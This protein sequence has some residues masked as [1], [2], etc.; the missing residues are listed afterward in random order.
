[1]V[2]RARSRRYANTALTSAS[3]SILPK[4]GIC[5][6]PSRMTVRISA[7]LK[8]S[9]SFA[10][11]RSGGAAWKPSAALRPAGTAW[12]LAQARWNTPAPIASW[13]FGLGS[14]ANAVPTSSRAANASRGR[15][16]GVP[17]ADGLGD[18][19]GLLEARPAG[20][21]RG[22]GQ[23]ERHQRDVGGSNADQ[24]QA[25]HETRPTRTARE[26]DPEA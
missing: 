25:Q 22:Q 9:S 20:D 21:Q 3:D 17:R 23:G 19:A 10:S 4:G 24:T 2:L 18:G 6:L 12:Q 26:N 11:N 13:L 15:D 7:S 16:T 14:Q 8:C 1:G 5:P